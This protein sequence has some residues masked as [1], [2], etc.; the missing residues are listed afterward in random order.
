MGKWS[1]SVVLVLCGLLTACVTTSPSSSLP[2]I[3]RVEEL[4]GR[5]YERIGTVQLSRERL[6]AEV[7]NVDDYA[8]AQT[9]LQEEAQKMGADAILPPELTISAQSFLLIPFTEIKA[10]ATAIRFR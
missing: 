4:S 2:A 10:R 8:W 3:V 7:L 6:G 1:L 5:G 9:A